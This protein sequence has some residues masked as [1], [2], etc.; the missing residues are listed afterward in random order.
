MVCPYGNIFVTGGGGLRWVMVIDN[1]GSL[2]DVVSCSL[3]KRSGGG[4]LYEVAFW[5]LTLRC[6]VRYG[7]P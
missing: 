3:R 6:F 5:S 1:Y 7:N 4:G 2:S